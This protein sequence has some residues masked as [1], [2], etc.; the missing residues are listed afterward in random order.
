MTIAANFFWHGSPL[1]LYENA[2]LSSFVHH[3]FDVR[4]HSFD[5]GLEV[6]EGSTLVDARTLAK[7]EEIDLRTQGGEKGCLASFSNIFRY[8]LLAREGGWWFD[9]DVFCLADSEAFIEIQD[10]SPG[11]SVAFEYD[12]Q[13]NGAIMYVSNTSIARELETMAI[14]KGYVIEW[15]AIGPSLI[16]EYYHAHPNRVEAP[17]RGTFYPVVFSDVEL[18]FDP[19]AKSACESAAAGSLCIHIHNTNRARRGIPKDVLP[20]AGSYL[21]TLFISVGAKSSPE[22]RLPVNVVQFRK[23]NARLRLDLAKLLEE[24][25]RLRLDLTSVHE[26]INRIYASKTWHL[27]SLSHR[28]ARPLLVLR[29]ICMRI[30]RAPTV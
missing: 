7:P 3:G 20:C 28:L 10:R 19:E 12:T 11:L 18:L 2:C 4:V 27:G 16:A 5:R 1:S 17:P 26:K 23:E 22:T 15:G 29:R 13:L 21:E 8:R 24:N 6:P 25:A 9:S 30:I 14:A